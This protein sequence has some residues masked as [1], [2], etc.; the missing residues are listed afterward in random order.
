MLGPRLTRS[1]LVAQAGGPAAAGDWLGA[2][3]EALGLWGRVSSEHFSALI[4]GL[5]PRDPEVRLRSS[6]RDPKVA[7][8]DLTF[9]APKSVSVLAAVASDEITAELI[10]AHEAAVRAA[11][12]YLEDTA[13]Q[14]RRG[15]D[16]GE[17]QA[18]TGLIAA[19]Y[20]E[21]A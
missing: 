10:L 8:L 12:A 13:V 15:H 14:V 16:G 5:D 7:A 2:G 21:S 18:G 20:P 19:A 9:S 3:T 11:V 1:E 6:D 4:A 17:V